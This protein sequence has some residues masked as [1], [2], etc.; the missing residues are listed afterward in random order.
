[1]MRLKNKVAVIT[2]AGCG[3]GLAGAIAFAGEGARVVIAEIDEELGGA[4][5]PMFAALAEKRPSSRR[6]VPAPATCRR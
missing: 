3:I 1:M 6:I 5:P 4:P 2:G